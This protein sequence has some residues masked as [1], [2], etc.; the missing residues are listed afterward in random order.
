[1][2]CSPMLFSSVVPP[3]L[4]SIGYL[5]LLCM[6][7]ADFRRPIP[8]LALHAQLTVMGMVKTLF[9]FAETINRFAA[10]LTAY[11]NC[12]YFNAIISVWTLL[13]IS[14]IVIIIATSWTIYLLRVPRILIKIFPIVWKIVVW[15]LLTEWWTKHSCIQTEQKQNCKFK[16]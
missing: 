2:R 5:S 6:N 14:A 1:M 9:S 10:K 11:Q 16:R 4:C 13:F 8:Y 15:W 12:T 7:H 3:M